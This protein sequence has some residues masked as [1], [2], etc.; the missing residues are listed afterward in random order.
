MRCSTFD[1]GAKVGGLGCSTKENTGFKG[2]ALARRKIYDDSNREQEL[3]SDNR[4]E[5]DRNDDEGML[6]Q[7]A[8]ESV[9]R[10]ACLGRCRVVTPRNGVLVIDKG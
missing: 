3:R 10:E 1:R 7:M 4:S 9:G 6:G 5:S 2:S 8:V